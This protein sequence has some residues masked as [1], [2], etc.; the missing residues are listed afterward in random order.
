[1]SWPSYDAIVVGAGIGGLSAAITLGAAGRRVL[2][3]E[4]HDS[5]GGKAGVCRLEGVE[6]DTG[7]SVLTL[8]HVFEQLLASAGLEPAR[9]LRLRRASPSFRYLYPDGISLDVHHELDATLRSVESALGGEA[10][11]EFAQFL[12]YA[13]RIWEAAA[14]AFVFG[15]A[16][17]V[18]ALMAQGLRGLSALSR[19][20]PLQTMRDAIEKR[21]RSPHLRELLARYGT[22]NGSDV[23]SAPATLNCIAHVE[24]AL[25]GFGVEGGIGALVAALEHAARKLGV[26]FR[27]GARV[28]RLWLRAGRVCGVQTGGAPIAAP[29]V[30][31]NADVAHVVADLLGTS[32]PHG[33]R[34]ASRPSMSGYNAIY[35][36]RRGG[37]VPH[38]VLFS[39]DHAKELADIFDRDSPPSEPTVYVCSQEACHGR[40]GW[41]EH[42]PLFVMA[43]APAEPIEGERDAAVWATLRARVH[44]RLTAAGLLEPDARLLWE[45]TP[46]DLARL[47]PRSRGAI[48]G[49]ASSSWYS[50]F[51][52]PDNAVRSVPGLFLAS[53][54]VHP[55]G[56]L[57][58][59]AQSGLNA[60]RAALAFAE[61]S[62]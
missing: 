17:G 1:M 31:M 51:Q 61:G 47:Y 45:R 60:A 25:G 62:R 19:I 6:V 59:A 21:V 39:S 34:L 10:A 55:G 8:P 41:P 20:D 50:A 29:V 16:P 54:S 38:T 7:P 53:G 52:R 24:L 4:A 12:A 37:R 5:A 14:P 28:E 57:P 46:S 49:A 27:F 26:E 9:A 13:G 42:E 58:L 36:A 43:N 22:Y 11:R 56:G 2:V 44:E 23:R 15:A 35:R 48:Y 3:L 18:V 33:I 30:V 40:P 32:V